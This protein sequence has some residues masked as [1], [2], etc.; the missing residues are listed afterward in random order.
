MMPTQMTLWHN[1]RCA[2]S[3]QALAL[4]QDAGHQPSVRLYLTD[5]PSEDEIIALRNA[6][7]VTA[8]AMMRR[9]EKTFKDLN[10]AAADEAALIDAM[11]AHPIL[12]ERPVL[13]NDGKAA[14]G[15]PP[16]TVL[17]IL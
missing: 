13:I 9:G 10:L 1:P 15:R 6:L 3:R 12:I 2:K 17:T 14:I 7:G 16:E 5:P 8:D 4:L 11:V